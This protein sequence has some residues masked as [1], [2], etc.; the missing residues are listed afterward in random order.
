LLGLADIRAQSRVVVAV[1]RM[2]DDNFGD[3]KAVGSGVFETRIHFGPGY[4][5]YFARRGSEIVVLLLCGAK[6][7]QQADIQRAIALH[8][9]L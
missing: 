5:V 8:R 4:R 2:A 3:H 1:E 9:S 6:P 7:T